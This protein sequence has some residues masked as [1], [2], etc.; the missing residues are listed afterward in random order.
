MRRRWRDYKTPAG[1]SPVEKFIDD[2]SDDNAAAALKAGM[3]VVLPGQAL[4]NQLPLDHPKRSVRRWTCDQ[5]A[6]VRANCAVVS[7]GGVRPGHGSEIRQ[8]GPA[9]PDDE[10]AGRQL[11]SPEERA[12]A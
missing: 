2:L 7:S 12:A 5:S 1:R 6:D 3:G 4:R 8:N 11:W 9:T 10:P